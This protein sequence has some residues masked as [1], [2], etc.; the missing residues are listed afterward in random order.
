V[1]ITKELEEARKKRA[2]MIDRINQLDQERQRLLQEAL[3]M[4]GEVRTLERLNTNTGGKK[5]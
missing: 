1:D 2:E 4:D 3:R 5:E